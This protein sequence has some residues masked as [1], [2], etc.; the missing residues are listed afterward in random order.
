M[1]KDFKFSIITAFY[2]TEIYIG[3]SIDSLINQ[4]LNFE[5]NV[6]LILVDDGS[7]DGSPK[8]CDK[9]ATANDNVVCL[10]KSNGGLSDARNYGTCHATGDYI[11]YVDSDDYV[12]TDYISSMIEAMRG[13]SVDIVIS[14][15]FDEDE[16]GK[17]LTPINN[18]LLVTVYDAQGALEEMCY[19]RKFGTTAC[20]KLY[21]KSLIE[22]FPFP[23]GRLYEDLSTIYK[24]IGTSKKIVFIQKAM[25]HYV[26]RKGSIRKS[27]WN[28]SV[29]DVVKASD[30]LLSY[31]SKYYPDIK[32]AAVQRYF[33]SANEVFTHAFGQDNYLEL[34]Q[35]ISRN[36]TDMKLMRDRVVNKT[37]C[38]PL[39]SNN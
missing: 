36:F 1:Q 33:F 24:V 5:D 39:V 29:F 6:Q 28:D 37:Y 15:H 31:I 17:I 8:L 12:D 19:E 4:T 14:S 11:S 30:E 38:E 32:K 16:N 22:Q 13:D 10:H 7:T 26:Q 25:Y 2:N 23:K 34:I 18:T 3:E 27:I 35:N 20:A 9:Y 21:K